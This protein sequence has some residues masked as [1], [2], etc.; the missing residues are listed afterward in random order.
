MSQYSRANPSP[1]YRELLALYARMHKEGSDD[2]SGRREAFAGHSLLRHVARIRELVQATAARTILDYGAGKGE[3]Y[4][5]MPVTVDGERV[6]DSVAEYWDVDEVRCYDPG[7]DPFR[8][9]PGSQYDGVV[10]TDVLEHCPEE[11]LRWIIGELFG[12]ARRFVFCS[13]ACH[14]ARKQ[15][16]NGE[17]AH[18]TVRPPEWWRVLFL[19]CAAQRPGVKWELHALTESGDKLVGQAFRDSDALRQEGETVSA[20]QAGATLT[21]EMEGRKAHFAV[22]N[23][24]T[25]WRA[26]TLYS[27]EP[28]TI[29]WLRTIE[30]GSVVY[31]IGAN[32]GLYTV[33]AALARQATVYAFEPESQ[34]YALLNANVVLNGLNGRVAAFCLALSDSFAVDRLYLSRVEAGGSCHSFGAEVGFDLQPRPAAYAQGCVSAR[35]DDLCREGGLPA[36]RYVKIDVD[37]LEHRVLRGMEQTLRGPDVRSLIVELNCRL[38]EHLEA[39]SW[40]ERLGYRWDAAQVARSTRVSGTFEGLAE[41]VFTR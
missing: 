33:F 20:D 13:V 9:L 12:L 35:L 2:G 38:P 28:V 29:D 36:P 27:K 18:V 11:D 5:P 25:R 16:P 30:S 41:H 1:R 34:N 21:I 32:V 6:A 23:E 7:H 37:G 10:C 26:K 39:R 4:R 24:A 22:P 14:P 40:L 19:S 31:D 3:V 15:L 8:E 17:N